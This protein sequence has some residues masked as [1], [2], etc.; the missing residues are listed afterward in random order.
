M[1]IGPNA[2]MP[3][4]ASGPTSRRTRSKNP[5]TLARVSVGV[6]VGIDSRKTSSGLDT[7]QPA[8]QTNFVPPAS[9]AP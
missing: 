5:A 6:P 4:P 2:A 7:S 3:I 9:I 8:A 1:S